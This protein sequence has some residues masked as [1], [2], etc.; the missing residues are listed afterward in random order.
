MNAPSS[1]N[2]FVT[3]HQS[4][5]NIA[6]FLPE[7]ALAVSAL[8]QDK[9]AFLGFKNGK[10]GTHA[11]RSLMLP[12]LTI[13]MDD[14]NEQ[15][16]TANIIE[17]IEVFNC[18]HKATTNSRKL[19]RRHLT[20]LY[21]FDDNICLFRRF[22][23][24]WNKS[25]E[26][27]PVLALQLA[28]CRDPL[29]RVSMPLMLELQ[30]GEILTRQHMEDQLEAYNPGGYSKAS[31]T[32]F[33]QNI[34]GSWTQAGFLQGK[35][36]KIRAIPEV[37]IENV[38]FALFIAHLHGYEG[39]RSFQ[40]NWVKILSTDI[41]DLYTKTQGASRHGHLR[42]KHASEVVEVTFPGWLTEQEK[43]VLNG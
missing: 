27:R 32:S 4:F 14:F 34:N 10:S 36:K 11:A 20:D 12:E 7:G 6:V 15:T 29:L 31:K 13:L 35:T 42:F 1:G 30:P 40:T 16:S 18:L 41:D 39:Q 37:R 24:L 17:N 23:Q 2:R 3:L 8:D 25:T 21:G 43:E 22:R 26:A 38:A 19:T 9:S 28:L 5:S 33:A